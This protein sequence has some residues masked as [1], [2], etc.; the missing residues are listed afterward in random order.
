MV[1]AV[2]PSVPFEELLGGHLWLC[3]GN[4]RVVGQHQVGCAL[5]VTPVLAPGESS[6]P[7][8]LYA[9]AYSRPLGIIPENSCNK[10]P[11]GITAGMESGSVHI[12]SS[13]L[14][15]LCCS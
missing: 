5:Q 3:V 1:L 8:H 11:P 4:E 2:K 9:S 13:S 14:H 12:P 10:H 6:L 7:P 15:A